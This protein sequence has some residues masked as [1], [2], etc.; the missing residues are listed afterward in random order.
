[1]LLFY[2][3]SPQVCTL[4]KCKSTDLSTCGQPVETAQTKFDMFSLSGTFGTNYVFPEVLYSDVQLAPGEFE[5]MGHS[6]T[7]WH[8]VFKAVV[9]EGKLLWQLSQNHSG[10]AEEDS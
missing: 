1:M 9:L 2:I 3:L 6:K 5:V 10:S 8:K 7:V 4:L